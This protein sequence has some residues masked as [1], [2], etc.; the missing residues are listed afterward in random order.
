M[1][2]LFRESF[3]KDLSTINDSK[4]LSRIERIIL[5]VESAKSISEINNIKKLKGA[6]TAFRIRVGDYR[7]GL[8]IK[9]EVTEFIRVLHRKDIYKYFP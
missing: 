4:V 7:I 5:E 1:L 3:S 2:S 9:G 6:K 8:F